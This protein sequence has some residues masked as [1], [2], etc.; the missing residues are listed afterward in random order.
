MFL[1]CANVFLCFQLLFEN[2]FLCASKHVHMAV[3][4]IKIYGLG[5]LTIRKRR[6]IKRKQQRNTIN[7]DSE[8]SEIASLD[9]AIVERVENLSSSSTAPPPFTS[10]PASQRLLFLLLFTWT[11]MIAGAGYFK[12]YEHWTM[13]EAVVKRNNNDKERTYNDK[14]CYK[15]ESIAMLVVIS[16]VL[17]CR[18]FFSTFVLLP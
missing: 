7:V 15:F 5:I 9:A 10:L 11:Y 17:C 4:V 6:K 8:L 14:F 2:V 1:F 16:C 18:I 13:E 12:Y 3:E